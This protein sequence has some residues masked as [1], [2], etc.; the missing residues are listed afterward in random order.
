MSRLDV[1]R[2]LRI[3][4]YVMQLGGFWQLNM[5]AACACPLTRTTGRLGQRG[6]RKINVQFLGS[7]DACPS[8]AYFGIPA[9]SVM[10]S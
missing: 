6:P 3:A 9:A 8:G 5:P 1:E 2:T 7:N 10:S 4:L